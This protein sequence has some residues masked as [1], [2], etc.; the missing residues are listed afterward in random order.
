M[1]VA[2]GAVASM[3]VA[4]YAV[5]LYVLWVSAEMWLSLVSVGWD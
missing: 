3:A 5:I 4:V 1:R 2:L